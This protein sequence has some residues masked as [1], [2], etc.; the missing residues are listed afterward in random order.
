VKPIPDDTSEEITRNQPAEIGRKKRREGRDST[1]TEDRRGRCRPVGGVNDGESDLLDRENAGKH[2][3]KDLL[4]GPENEKLGYS[5][6]PEVQK[7]TK[8][9]KGASHQGRLWVRRCS[10][11]KAGIGK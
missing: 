11:G 1:E 6:G 10:S 9:C 3:K 7:G 4:E 2:R 5:V 8:L